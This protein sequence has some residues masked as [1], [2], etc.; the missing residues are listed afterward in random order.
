MV[1]PCPTCQEPVILN[2]KSEPILQNHNGFAKRPV[3]SN[4]TKLTNETIRVRTKSGDTPLHRAAK[5]GQF[6]LIPSNILSHD[7]FL[8][9]NNAGDTPL[10]LA[11]RYGNLNQVPT[12]YL[13]HETLTCRTSPPYAP[14][15]VYFTGSGKEAHTE[16]VLHV[17][18]R[19]KHI[20]QIPGK[21]LT[22]AYLSLVATGYETTLLED[23]AQ[24][25]QLD[26]IPEINTDKQIWELKNS[27]GQ[28]LQ[29]ILEARKAQADYISKV[30]SEP[31]TEKQKSKLRWFDYPVRDGMTKGE[32]SD[33]I[34]Q[35]V[36]Q[37]P[38][39]EREYYERPATK[40]QIDQLRDYAKTDEDLAAMFEEME[41]EESSLTYRE[42]KDLILD[43]ERG[44][45]RREID[46]LTNPPCESQIKQLE[47]LGF[48]LDTKIDE[49]ITG[50]DLAGILNLK[51][52]SPRAE[53]SIL[54]E[55][56]GITLFQG[57]GLAAFALG[58]L[59]RSFG[60]SAQYHNRKNVNYLAACQA[61]L[62]DPAFQCPKLT[63]DEDRFLA[64]AWPK[65]KIS[66][67]LRAA[68]V[69]L[70]ENL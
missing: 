15:G 9:A 42:A 31:I 59:I 66:E 38:E 10:H 67:W 60:G 13:S 22:P 65:S 69:D 11:A 58:D 40:E 34:D 37:N 36:R 64:F 21:F 51:G 16:T 14:H 1:V 5:N 27:C 29:D 39:K 26:L 28:T 33:A 43:S 52:A 68:K 24:S 56:H 53:D 55:Q 70:R 47:E 4:L 12:K 35:C 45:Q 62:N 20:E 3:R 41:L 44:A 49:I 50:A 32:A 25:D 18:A 57:D 48:K 30:R 54:L 61:A 2:P 7:L 46:L 19:Y 23:I 63:R 6:D 17:A 8:V